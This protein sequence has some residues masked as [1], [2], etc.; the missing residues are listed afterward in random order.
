MKKLFAQFKNPKVVKITAVLVIFFSVMATV[1]F[2]LKTTQRI[3]I[4][5]SVVSSP[6]IPL[7]S[8][9]PGKLKTISAI[10]GQKVKKGD[11]LAI[12]GTEIIR[13][14]TDGIIVE[15]NKQIGAFTSPQTPIVKMI[16]TSEMRIDGTIDENKG[17]S[18]IKI[19]QVVSFT[20][21]ALPGQTFWGYVDEIAQ[22]AKQT[23]AT[24]SISSERPTQQFEI[25][26]R[27]DSN[28]YPEIKNGMSAKMT[29]YT[30]M[31]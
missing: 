22:S 21:D 9:T 14:Y 23:G 1:F 31:P 7:S 26:A 4:E 30:N 3:N 29:V 12:V 28:S 24:F 13:P 6:I 10:E 19:G 16:N 18:Q 11:A 15:T 20:I 8:S 25:Y 27:F 2:Y 17:L 5:N